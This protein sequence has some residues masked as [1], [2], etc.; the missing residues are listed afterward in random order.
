MLPADYHAQKVL[1]SNRVFCITNEQA[2]KSDIRALRIGIL[3][4][5][6]EAK[7]YEFSLLHPL[8]RSVLQIIPVWIKL[9]SHAY[10][11]TAKNHLDNL[12]L[13]FEEAIK[14]QPL[15]GMIIT[16]APVEHLNFKEVR[17]WQE[18]E[19]IL[20]I[21]RQT[22]P[23]TLGICWGG[24]ALAYLLGIDKV[25]YPK[26]MFGV[27]ETVNLNRSH[28]IT[29]GLDDV[30]WLPQSRFSGYDNNTLEMA[31]KNKQICLLAQTLGADYPIFES[32]DRRFIVNLGHF[33]Y[34][35]SRF[36]EE[37]NRDQTREDVAAPENFNLSEPI[38]RWRGQ[39][40]EF[41]YQWLRY[42][43][44]ATHNQHTQFYKTAYPL[45]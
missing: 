42:C 33:E 35:S 10:T 15:D 38:N 17:Y 25:S 43:H 40:N 37:Y 28:P 31:E 27:F 9:H 26:K 34:A 36:L 41:F 3:N 5:M 4:V 39:R 23:S 44:E 21:C 14:H 7:S 6:P 8:G 29:G 16:G 20:M 11:S 30:F 2:L 19:Q 45:P 18:L 12:Y 22:V 13:Y 24:M 1:E 32:Y